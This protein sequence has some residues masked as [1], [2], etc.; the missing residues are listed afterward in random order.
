MKLKPVAYGKNGPTMDKEFQ[1]TYKNKEEVKIY[2]EYQGLKKI[3]TSYV[4]QIARF[5]VAI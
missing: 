2:S 5:M 4:M 1:Q 3:Y